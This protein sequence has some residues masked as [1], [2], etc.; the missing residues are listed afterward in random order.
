MLLSKRLELALELRVLGHLHD[1]GRPPLDALA[2]RLR[3]LDQASF[4]IK[5]APLRKHERMNVERLGD[6]LHQRSWRV[7]KPHRSALELQRVLVDLL[8]SLSG[9][10]R[11]PLVVSPEC[12]L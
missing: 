5:L 8:G 7:G 9:W 11:T 4:A 10:H 2:L 12:L 3:A 6:I 1:R